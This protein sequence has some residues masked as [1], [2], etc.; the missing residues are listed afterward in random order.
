MSMATK[1]TETKVIGKVL[2]EKKSV[3]W[4]I[5]RYK[6]NPLVEKAKKDGY[7]DIRLGWSAWRGQLEITV[8]GELQ[9]DKQMKEEIRILL[10]KEQSIEIN[11]QIMN[12]VDL[13]SK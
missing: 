11:S 7:T 4:D 5:F 3:S 10:G 2:F 9:T 12:L 8:T 6:L 13:I 1:K